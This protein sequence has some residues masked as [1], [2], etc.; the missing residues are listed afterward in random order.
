M[1]KE[2]TVYESTKGS[3]REISAPSEYSF[4][5][6][7]IAI[8]TTADIMDCDFNFIFKNG[9]TTGLPYGLG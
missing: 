9:E 5:N 3:A 8:E 4:D 1:I 6:P 2:Y 7:L